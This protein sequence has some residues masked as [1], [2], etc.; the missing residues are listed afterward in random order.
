MEKPHYS[1][2]LY[3]FFQFKATTL[4]RGSSGQD[5]KAGR[6]RS[7]LCFCF[8]CCFNDMFHQQRCRDCTDPAGYRCDCLDDRFNFL[9]QAVAADFLFFVAPGDS[10]IDDCLPRAEE[11]TVKDFDT[12]HAGN[13]NVRLPGDFRHVLGTCVAD[14]NG[15]ILC[16]QHHGQRSSHYQGTADNDS[17]FAGD[18][19]AIV[20]QNGDCRFCSTWSEASAV[21]GKDTCQ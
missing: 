15:G 17:V 6:K 10:D 2:Y 13:D 14:R 1:L 9:E 3:N 7:A 5:K 20:F 18:I 8:L 19:D 11:R 16:H 4:P 12:A 21:A